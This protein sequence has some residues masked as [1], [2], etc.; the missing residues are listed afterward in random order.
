MQDNQWKQIDHR[1]P[2]HMMS[3]DVNDAAESLNMQY[4]NK[5][6]ERADFDGENEFYN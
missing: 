5:T 2:G 4:N 6:F 1:I 3:P